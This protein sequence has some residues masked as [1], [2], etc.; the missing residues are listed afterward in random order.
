ME[1]S[2]PR[3]ELVFAIGKSKGWRHYHIH[4]DNKDGPIAYYG[5]VHN[6]KRGTPT[7]ELRAGASETDPIV[8][9]SSVDCTGAGSQI[10]LGD[11]AQKDTGAL[12]Y[13]TLRTK[14][15]FTFK[16]YH[17][18]TDELNEKRQRR[19]YSW[20]RTKT[21]PGRFECRDTQSGEVLAEFRSNGFWKWTKIGTVTMSLPDPSPRAVEFLLLVFL[22]WSEMEN[23]EAAVI[24][25]IAS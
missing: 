3:S 7:L 18:E 13:E 6:F 4:Q 25:A 8:G 22:S 21:S 20:V 1:K 5:V 17:F 23:R 15:A 16:E 24:A 9:F 2:T 19:Q 12:D 14:R 10:A 11:P